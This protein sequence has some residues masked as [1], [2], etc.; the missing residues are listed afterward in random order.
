MPSSPTHA[1]LSAVER[2]AAHGASAERRA[3]EPGAGEEIRSRWAP[4][5]LPVP[6]CLQAVLQ[7]GAWV[8][9]AHSWERKSPRRQDFEMPFP[10][11]ADG[12][13]AIIPETLARLRW[14]RL[15]SLRGF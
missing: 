10:T 15:E 1:P 14:L 6:P 3:L 7:P 12:A 8:L 2:W 5:W 13:G 4:C 9:L 11:E